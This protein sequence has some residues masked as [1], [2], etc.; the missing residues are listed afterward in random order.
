MRRR[1]PI[2]LMRRV[3]QQRSPRTPA[4]S[5]RDGRDPCGAWARPVLTQ[6][7]CQPATE[8]RKRTRA[9]SGGKDGLLHAGSTCREGERARDWTAQWGPQVS[10]PTRA[11]EADGAGPHVGARDRSLGRNQAW[12][13]KSTVFLLFFFLFPFSLFSYPI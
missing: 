13:P 1:R 5:S 4:S 3:G 9:K 6:G 10:T 7:P 2:L 8:R 12:R 11:C